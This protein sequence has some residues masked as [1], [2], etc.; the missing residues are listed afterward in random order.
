MST[1]A[2]IEN[3]PKKYVQ[4]YITPLNAL[5]LFPATIAVFLDFLSPF[6]PFL[7]GAAG[8]AGIGFL[9]SMIRSRSHTGSKTNIKKSMLSVYTLVSF[10]VLSGAATANFSQRHNGGAIANWNPTVKTWQDAYLRGIKEDTAEIKTSAAQIEK[11]LAKSNAMLAQ[12]LNTVRPQLEKTLVDEVPGYASLKSNQKDA[13][14]LFTSKVGTNGIKRYRGL[15]KAIKTYADAPTDQ[16]Q[17][18]ITDH[19]RYVVRINGKTVD[20]TRTRE[21]IVALFLDPR[22]YDYLTGYG[23]APEAPAF[24]SEFNINPTQDAALQIADPLGDLIKELEAKGTPISQAVVIPKSENLVANE[25]SEKRAAPRK[26][27]PPQVP[28]NRKFFM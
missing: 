6:G 21:M 12:L 24:Y 14:I 18:E 22:L 15:L 2:E 5:C 8:L 19:I 28:V 27:E 9:W 7:I 11:S 17:R 10:L 13:L 16:N 23:P 3:K 4:D 25:K 26:H 20:D 1:A